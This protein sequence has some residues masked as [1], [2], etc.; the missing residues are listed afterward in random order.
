MLS[1]TP[2]LLWTAFSFAKTLWSLFYSKTICS[3]ISYAR[4][5]APKARHRP[6]ALASEDVLAQIKAIREDHETA[7]L[8]QQL[9]ETVGAG[10]WPPQPSH[11]DSWPEALRPYH[12][13]Y[14]QLAPL[15][16]AKTVSL[17]ADVN[18]KRRLKFQT[19]MRKLLH[20]RVDLLAVKA[21]LSASEAGDVSAIP[22]DVCHGFYSCITMSRHAFR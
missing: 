7:G 5:T 16:P 15:L 21:L 11:G 17:D 6:K 2:S 8:L 4:N 1:P 9:I 10:R 19:R 14:V 18:R 22:S 3:F 13:I 20:D 12:A